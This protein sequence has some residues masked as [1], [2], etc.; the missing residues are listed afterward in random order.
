MKKQKSSFFLTEFLYIT[1][2]IY[3]SYAVGIGAVIF[4]K[5]PDDSEKPVT[6]ASRMLTEAENNYSQ[7]EKEAL[8]LV[9]GVVKEF[10][11]SICLVVSLF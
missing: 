3:H 7:T 11:R 10:S 4:H 5:M 2:Q 8:G 9:F 1:N 6:F